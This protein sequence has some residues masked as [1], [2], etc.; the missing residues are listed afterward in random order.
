MTLEKDAMDLLKTKMEVAINDLVCEKGA[1]APD[2]V[3]YM[4]WKGVN[5]AQELNNVLS[6]SEAA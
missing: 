3:E 4:F 1:Y 2:A 6:A 5:A